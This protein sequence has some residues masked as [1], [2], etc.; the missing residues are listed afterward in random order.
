MISCHTRMDTLDILSV[1][2][3]EEEDV[4]YISPGRKLN[5]LIADHVRPLPQ[6][7][8]VPLPPIAIVT[9]MIT[10]K[11][12]ISGTG[13]DRRNIKSISFIARS[14]TAITCIIDMQ[15]QDSFARHA[16]LVLGLS[17]SV[18][19]AVKNTGVAGMPLWKKGESGNPKGRPRKRLFDDYL[20]EAL[21]AKR[22]AAAKRLVERLIGEASMGNVQALKLVCERI[23]GKPK[24][25]EDAAVSNGDELT[26]V[27]VRA[28]LA[29]LL[30]RPE[31]KRNLQ[32]LLTGSEEEPKA[33]V[34]Q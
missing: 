29:E 2:Y 33:D 6:V 22:G 25:A 10:A 7:A 17:S 8:P 18:A 13:I 30:S 31:V 20:R 14:A 26:L 3:T 24:N 32:S 34:L 16:R 15:I 12:G 21:S 28:K 11:T 5:T 23:G 27:Q 4:Q 1:I 19:S 9:E